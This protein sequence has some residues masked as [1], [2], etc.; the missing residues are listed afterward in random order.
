[1]PLSFAGEGFRRL[2][3]TPFR[4]WNAVLR[5]VPN[6]QDQT[7]WKLTFLRA[8]FQG[9]YRARATF[10]GT[11]RALAIVEV[12]KMLW[13]VYVC[14]L[15]LPSFFY[16]LC[17]CI[18]VSSC[19]KP[20]RLSSNLEPSRTSMSGFGDGSHSEQLCCSKCDNCLTFVPKRWDIYYL[21]HV[22]MTCHDMPWHAMTIYCPYCAWTSSWLRFDFCLEID[23]R[24]GD[25][26]RIQGLLPCW[27]L[28]KPCPSLAG[29]HGAGILLNV[30]SWLVRFS[31]EMRET[32]LRQAIIFCCMC[33]KYAICRKKLTCHRKVW[34]TLSAKWETQCPKIMTIQ[35]G[36]E[37]LQ[38]RAMRLLVC[39]STPCFNVICCGQWLV[40]PKEMMKFHWDTVRI[41]CFLDRMQTSCVL[42]H[43]IFVGTLQR[44]CLNPSLHMLHLQTAFSLYAEASTRSLLLVMQKGMAVW[45]Q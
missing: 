1:M 43:I 12:E 21:Q 37:V 36:K 30:M 33:D 5:T 39:F 17:M 22:A 41:Q 38:A 16:V 24:S 20:Y 40:D 14:F 34:S 18:A 44:W 32:C 28:S 29:I 13:F 19:L 9:T 15:C 45:C 31:E 7:P 8:T 3:E 2:N 6:R 11:Y 26:L 35:Q 27:D 23:V 25:K 4:L 10:K 42:S